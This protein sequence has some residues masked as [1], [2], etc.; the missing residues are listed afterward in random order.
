MDDPVGVDCGGACEFTSDRAS[1]PRATAVVFH[2][3]T[4]RSMTLPRKR[5]GQ[6]WAAWSMESRKD[7]ELSPEFQAMLAVLRDPPCAGSATI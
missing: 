7:S 2:I 5:P 3:P 1:R 4:L 6:P